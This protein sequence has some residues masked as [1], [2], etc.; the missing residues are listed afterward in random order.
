ML[1]SILRSANQAVHFALCVECAANQA[2]LLAVCVECR[3]CFE[4]MKQT[5]R[6]VG[7]VVSTAA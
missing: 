7:A 5:M 1:S 6:C 2:V 3:V 4:I